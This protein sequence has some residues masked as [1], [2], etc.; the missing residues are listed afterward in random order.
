MLEICRGV[1]EH[2]P[3]KHLINQDVVYAGASLHDIGK[4]ITYAQDEIG[5][6][7]HKIEEYYAGH[8]FYGMAHVQKI[9]IEKNIDNQFLK[10]ILHVIASHHGCVEHG[11]IK[12]P[13]SLEAIV[14]SQ[15]DYLSSRIGMLD[16][17]FN[18][19][20]KNGNK[21]E[22]EYRMH[23]DRYITGSAIKEWIKS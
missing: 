7:I 22:E 8:L 17:K 20:K 16:A 11:S 3:C 4:T 5:Q 12:P 19:I 9:G 21:L 18:A 10:E 15:A 2:F 14:V 1:V 6:P 13:C 23:D